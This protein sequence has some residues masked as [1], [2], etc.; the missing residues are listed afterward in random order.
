MQI[1]V[2]LYTRAREH[3]Q[4]Y[5]Y[6]YLN[7]FQNNISDILLWLHSLLSVIH[8]IVLHWLTVSDTVEGN[9][10]FTVSISYSY[11]AY[12][13]KSSA[14]SVR[15]FANHFTKLW[16]HECFGGSF[17]KKELDKV[18]RFS[19]TISQSPLYEYCHRGCL[20]RSLQRPERA[21]ISHPNA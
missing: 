18:S 13:N 9:R 11:R 2:L 21:V 15:F 10:Y 4:F 16:S 12:K 7:W 20:C 5:Y 19:I 1:H 8:T 17:D 3:G 6:L 14:L